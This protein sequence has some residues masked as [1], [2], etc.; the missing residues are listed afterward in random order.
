MN[1]QIT[2]M[3]NTLAELQETAQQLSGAYMIAR[4]SL[5]SESLRA[6]LGELARE[7]DSTTAAINTEI[8]LLT[9]EV[10]AAVE[11]VGHSVKG[12]KLHA[13][14]TAGRV[15]WDDRFLKGYAATH[16]EILQARKEGQP[17]VSIRKC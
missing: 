1:D 10:K 11:V 12:L 15:S 7:Y 6:A 17:G 13:V 2:T 14:Y 16:E 8:T 3:L 9:T 5:I 4:D